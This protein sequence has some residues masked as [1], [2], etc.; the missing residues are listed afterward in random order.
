VGLHFLCVG[1]W[2]NPQ[3]AGRAWM[4]DSGRTESAQGRADPNDRKGTDAL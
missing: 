2:E 4:H 3:L 1:G